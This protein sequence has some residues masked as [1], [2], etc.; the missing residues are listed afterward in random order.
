VSLVQVKQFDAVLLDVDI[1]GMG[2]VEACRNIRYASAR[3]PILMLSAMDNVNVK[4]MALDAGADDYIT[5]PFRLRELA[6]RLRSAVRR[7]NAQD[8][9]RVAPIRHG[10]LELD[11]A[12]YRVQKG[13]RSI[14][15]SP[16]EFEMLH[17]FMIHAGESIPHTRLLKAVWG[18]EYREVVVY[19]RIYVGQLRKK[20]EDDPLNPK[21]LQ[22]V[23][24]VG[25][26]FCP[27]QP[28]Y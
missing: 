27:E 9:E 6:A 23:S 18:S 16:K 15:L 3:L 10:Q 13:G 14:H 19:L 26:R 24:H 21:Y 22:T 17:Y 11:V 20:I 28:E 8:D 1:P 4:E 5:K 25:Y 7:G 2:G 12:R